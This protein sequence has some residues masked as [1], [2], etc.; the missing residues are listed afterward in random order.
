[1]PNGRW[2]EVACLPEHWRKPLEFWASGPYPDTLLY[3]LNLESEICGD[4]L[5]VVV[6]AADKDGEVGKL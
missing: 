5:S 3:W 6:I 1:M 4:S 2:Y